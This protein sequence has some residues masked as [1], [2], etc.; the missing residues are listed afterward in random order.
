MK[1]LKNILSIAV[2]VFLI[3]VLS[4]AQSAN[5][6]LDASNSSIIVS[7]T[8]TLHDWEANAEE[9]NLDVLLN[10]EMITQETP[11]SPVS[12]LELTVPVSS[13]ESGKGKMN[14]KMKEA[15]KE[16][17]HPEIMFNLVSAELADNV[18][19]DSVSAEGVFNLT[20]TGNLTIAGVEKEVSFPVTGMKE[21]ENG[22]RFEGS[23]SLN[24]TNYKMDPPSVMFG[25]IK[26]GEEVTITFNILLTANQNQ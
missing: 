20:V 11:A 23:Y 24:M 26:S 19:A 13:L 16:D 17:D 2:A 15:L 7:G 21:G 1:T 3:P 4:L 6:T 14:R 9:M 5:Y 25:A 8:S 18:S 22:Y 12:S 10:P